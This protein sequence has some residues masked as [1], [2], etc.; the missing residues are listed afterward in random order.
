VNLASPRRPS[1]S[2][3]GRGVAGRIEAPL[4]LDFFLPLLSEGIFLVEGLWPGFL[5]A[6]RGMVDARCESWVCDCRSN[7]KQQ[8][9]GGK[10]RHNIELIYAK[11][12][13]IRPV[14]FR[15]IT[16]CFFG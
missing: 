8:N 15:D 12:W 14:C 1:S 4:G 9:R 3:A 10:V 5:E 6:L 11:Y 16:D 7:N 2:F 13:E